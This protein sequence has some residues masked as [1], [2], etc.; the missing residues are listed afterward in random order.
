MKKSIRMLA[1]FLALLLSFSALVGCSPARKPLTYLKSAIEKTV[2]RRFGG[3][4][5]EAIGNAL[6]S[7]SISL[8]FGGTDLFETVADSAELTASFDA[9]D[10]KMTLFASLTENGEKFDG[11]LYLTDDVLVLSSAAFLGSNTIGLNFNTLSGDI[12][13]SIFRNDSGT[14]FASPDIGAGTAEALRM[15]KDGFFSLLEDLDDIGDLGDEIFEL[16]LLKLAEASPNSVYSKSGRIHISLEVNNTTL[17]SA[18]RDTRAAI[19]K[20]RGICRELR[21]YVKVL[22]AIE[23]AKSGVTTTYRADELEAFLG[24]NAGLESACALI[25]GATPFSFSIDAVIKRSSRVVEALT[26]SLSRGEAEVFAFSADLTDKDTNILVL[27]VGGIRRELTYRVVKDGLFKYE[28]E[29]CYRK[30]QTTGEELFL[31]NA[32][33]S[34]NTRTDSFTLSLDTATGRRVYTGSFDEGLDSY[35]A[36]INGVTVDGVTHRFSLSFAVSEREKVEKPPE[37][38]NIFTISEDHFATISPRIKERR[39]ALAAWSEETGASWYSVLEAAFAT[40]GIAD[41]VPPP[42]PDDFNWKHLFP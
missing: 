16:F 18:L 4:L 24:S 1:L 32:S 11:K 9:D 21:G 28:A 14:V 40:L 27:T 12:Q 30:A 15:Q 37:Y 34:S 39:E 36:S 2:D 35:T 8:K 38:V 22:D 42:L 17:S 6:G 26:L 7:G 33:I 3:E 41:D 25:D 19:V 23:S 13:N 5:L 29:I 31:R 10:K 20:D